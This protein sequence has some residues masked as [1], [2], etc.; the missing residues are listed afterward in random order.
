[1][2]YLGGKSR[3]RKQIAAF[4]KSVRKP[5][6]VYFEPFV[7]GAWV[8]QEMDGER[9]AADGNPAL[10][11]M[12]QALQ[13]GW[14]PP[15]VVTEE[16]FTRYKQMLV[17]ADPMQAFVLIGCAFGGIWG[18]GYGRGNMSAASSRNSLL[19]QLPLVQSATFVC[20]D[21][22]TWAPAAQ[23]IYADPPYMGTTPY[24]ALP[25][26]DHD[27]FWVAMRKWCTKNI[28]VVSEY[29]APSDWFCVREFSTHTELRGKSGRSPRIE[30]LFMHESQ[31]TPEI[32]NGAPTK[33]DAWLAQL[34]AQ[35]ELAE[36]V[37]NATD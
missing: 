26:F 35:D 9:V 33:S 8:L 32:E 23:L 11:A 25:S 29:V 24:K 16:E 6:Q 12:Y 18:A 21:Y 15:S 10:I 2:Q 36:E 4:L 20:S 31:I 28:V 27:L 5:G 30:R 19:R 13:G 34:G 22:A 17:Q 7:G 14:E 3:I 37:V 1:V